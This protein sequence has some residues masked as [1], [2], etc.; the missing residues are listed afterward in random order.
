VLG[1]EIKAGQR[2][3]Q[4]TRPR[5]PEFLRELWIRNLRVADETVD[6]VLLRHDTDIGINVLRKTGGVEV[7]AIK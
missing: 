4:F 3:V 6:L 5:L 2:V 1:L 7:I